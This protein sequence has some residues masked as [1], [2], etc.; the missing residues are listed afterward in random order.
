M[1]CRAAIDRDLN[2][3]DYPTTGIGGCTRDSRSSVY[4]RT[5]HW[6][7]DCRGG[8]CSIRRSRGHDKAR[9][10]C[11]GLHP[12]ISKQI[13]HSLLHTYIRVDNPCEG[14]TVMRSIQSP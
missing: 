12:H 4:D 9:L 2:T 3:P 11:T 14:P 1:P 7:S 10:E 6:C 5:S 13:H 8:S